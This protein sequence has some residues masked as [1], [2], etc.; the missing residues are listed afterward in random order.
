MPG[1]DAVSTRKNSSLVPASSGSECHTCPLP[2]REPRWSDAKRKAQNKDVS[3]DLES[4]VQLGKLI[5]RIKLNIRVKIERKSNDVEFLSM[6]RVHLPTGCIVL[7][8]EM[9]SCMS[10]FQVDF[11]R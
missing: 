2:Y 10:C 1:R 5:D 8:P 7:V 3:A 4:Q 6:D 9:H 11:S